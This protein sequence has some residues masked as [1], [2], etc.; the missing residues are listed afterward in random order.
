ALKPGQISGVVKTQFG[1][2]IIKAE[3]IKRN[4][5]KDYAKNKAKALEDFK[6]IRGGE[7]IKDLM[8]EQKKTAQIVW[9]DDSLK[10]RY[11]YGKTNSMMGMPDPS[12]L[13]PDALMAE[14]KTYVAKNPDDA[15]ANVVLGQMLNTQYQFA[16]PGPAKEKV[17]D[18]IIKAYE[19][20]L[21][22]TE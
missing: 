12:A 7:A 16:P 14:L 22:H 13:R 1:F 10:W 3:S 2:H 15:A 9:H 17:R 18:E 21:K 5:P 6:R 11:D 8:D 20:G 4:L 19:A